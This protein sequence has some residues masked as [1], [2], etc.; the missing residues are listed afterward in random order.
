MNYRRAH[1][2][3]KLNYLGVFVASFLAAGLLV[4]GCSSRLQ[5]PVVV[6]DATL[7]EAH[8]SSDRANEAFR[9]ALNYTLA[10][11][12]QVDPN[13]GLF[14]ESL[15]ADSGKTI[16]DP[17]NNA[18][19]NLA[20]MAA[21]ALLLDPELHEI[22]VL[23]ILRAERELTARLGPLPDAYD[24]QRQEFEN[25]ILTNPPIQYKASEYMK[26][27]CLPLVE[28]FGRTV[29]CDRMIEMVDYMWEETASGTRSGVVTTIPEVHGE[30]LQVLT[31]LYWM[32]GEDKYL[33]WALRIGD[34][35]LLSRRHPTRATKLRLL[36][37]GGE[38][39]A[40]LAELYVTLAYARPEKRS[41]YEPYIHEM[42]DRILEIGRNEHGMFYQT[43]YP[44]T[45]GH[46]DAVADT[47]GY[48][49]NAYLCVY[50]V[51]QT[52]EYELVALD[53]L[54]VLMPHYRGYVWEDYAGGGPV[55][56][57]G[58][59][60]GYA[61]AIEGALGVLNYKH[62]ADAVAWIDS[63]IEALWSFQ[64]LD[65]LVEGWYAD[66]NFARTSLMYGLW[67]TRGLYVQP[68]KPEV[69]VG[70]AEH[71]GALYVSLRC[72]VE[73]WSGILR[74]DTPRHR[75]VL[76]LPIDWPRIGRFPEW[77]TA[78]A[79]EIYDVF[80]L[81]DNTHLVVTG[82]NL[83]SGI[84]FNLVPGQEHRLVVLKQNEPGR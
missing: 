48:I 50:L 83:A 43:I 37:H 61:D 11:M 40:G 16:W 69:Y 54:S 67:K 82:A 62:V 81:T 3:V 76:N 80:D 63:E 74:F 77:Y 39:V 79:A 59:Q 8:V 19:D 58:G 49:L 46:I 7:R 13:T 17:A 47:W 60:D 6:N 29:W 56:A 27:G 57:L 24:I 10:W 42:L 75:E 31:R 1:A 33:E 23:P 66:G 73:P 64:H 41:E 26:D 36:D 22:A 14:P 78:E 72:E 70:A 9:R 28:L 32:T 21:T 4:S 34:H 51:D 35:Y 25:P 68:W 52:P 55:P 2:A 5:I 53:I 18:A 65:G 20:Y 45:G 12:E 38:I 71:E 15:I 84:P 30:Q 44:V